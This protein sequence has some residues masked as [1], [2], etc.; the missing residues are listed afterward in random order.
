MKK[1]L[2]ILLSAAMLTS[3]IGGCSSGG[4]Q[5][6]SAAS[7]EA[8]QA[9][10]QGEQQGN[11]QGKVKKIAF[12]FQDLETQFWVAGH[13]AVVDTLKGKG[14]EVVEYNGNQDAN[15]QL[16][17]VNDAIAQNVDGI[18]LIPQDGES[19]LTMIKTANKADV[20]IAIFNRPP[21]TEDGNAIVVVAD[22]QNVAYKAGQHMVAQAKALYEKTKKKIVVGHMIGDLGDPN[23]IAR[24]KGFEAAMAEAPDIFGK[25]VEIPT[26]WDA[27]TALANLRNAMQANSDIGMIFCGSD[28]LYPQIQSVLEP[29]GKWKKI[30][31]DNH[32]ILGAVD[33]DSTAGKL[34]DE[35]YVD[36]TG[37]QD[38]YF[39]ANA[40]MEEIIKAVEAGN[41]Q[42]DK[43]VQD[44]G[45]ALTQA[46][47]KEMH[48]K[49][50]GNILSKASSGS[51]QS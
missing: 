9:A 28:F 46:N 39:E 41:K 19:A 35:G 30:G 34:M 22:N 33:G 42:P 6:S 10:S 37:V 13:K 7:S 43:T 23:A 4:S 50:W 5:T 49:M 15:K 36:A 12:C 16:E 25:T 44:P 8:G 14:I 40:C 47:M 48:D 38:V 31:D 3:L 17:Q 1:I 27:N 24:K 21:T 18:I 2:A 20:P 29:L 26:K 45:F 32:I 11:A 51:S